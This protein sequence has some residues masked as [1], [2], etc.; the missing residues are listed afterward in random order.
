MINL[1]FLNK[2]V[3]LTD[4]NEFRVLYTIANTISLK[5]EGRTR[6]YREMLSDMLGLSTKQITRLTNSLE[7]K[8]LLRKD[9]ISNGDKT[10]CYYSLNLDIIDQ[11]STSNRDKNVPLNNSKKELIKEKRVNNRNKSEKEEKVDVKM[12]FKTECNVDFEEALKST[13][14]NKNLEVIELI[15]QELYNVQSFEDL[16]AVGTKLRC[17]ISKYNDPYLKKHL[18]DE[19]KEAVK[20]IK[21]SMA[22][23]QSIEASLPF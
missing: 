5:K 4:G 20:R 6:I 21:A 7:D 14:E 19:I 11:K 10:V 3:E 17:V 18:E 22:V 23:S 8:G 2:A 1:K 9:L 16:S 13:E 12:K 15:D